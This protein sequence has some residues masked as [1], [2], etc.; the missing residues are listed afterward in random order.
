MRRRNQVLDWIRSG[1]A[2][3]E[4]EELT[5]HALRG[6]SKVDSVIAIGKA[7]PAMAR[8]AER[9]LGELRGICVTHVPDRVPQGLELMVGDHPV[10]GAASL[11]AGFK[12]MEWATRA[13]LA[14]I[15]GGGSSL[16]EVPVQGV[17]IER[18]VAIHS[19]LLHSGASID[20][21]NL[22]RGALSV[23]KCGGL[24][25]IETLLISDVGPADP[26]VVSSG[27]TIPNPQAADLAHEVLGKYEIPDVED[28][29]VPPAAAFRPPRTTILA[30]GLTAACAIAAS[31]SESVSTEVYDHWITDHVES[32]LERFFDRAPQSGVLVGAGEAPVHVVNGGRGGRCTHAALLA[33]TMI[34]ET[35]WVFAAI[36]SDGSDGSSGVA[37]ACVDGTTTSRAVGR[38]AAALA[39]FD[40][41]E[42]LSSSGDVV[43]WGPT[44]TN[45][46]DLWVLWKP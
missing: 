34:E 22:V 12:I 25:P 8:G 27:P 11:A 2:A 45:V 7:A 5:F 32:A 9:A 15:S 46:A 17:G 30:D 3:V 41:A 31:A 26:G 40:S 16:A 39:S 29:V 21:M 42:Y 28:I 44:G 35:D 10:P 6:R 43:D 38:A 4:P 37:G 36:A 1:I 19:A 14:L 33:A 13:E 18:M 24:G 20:E 23:I